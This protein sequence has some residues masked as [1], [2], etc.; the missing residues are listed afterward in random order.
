VSLW[1]NLS[2]SGIN[3]IAAAALAGE[4]VCAGVRPEGARSLAPDPEAF[5]E[6]RVTELPAR[7]ET[8]RPA[9]IDANAF[10]C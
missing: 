10:A 1:F 8:I 6:T 3:S 5:A 7:V 4:G 2:F 9:S